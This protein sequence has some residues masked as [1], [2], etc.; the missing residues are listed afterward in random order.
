[1]TQWAIAADAGPD[2][3]AI[4]A[5]V[6]TADFRA[7]FYPGGSFSLDTAMGWMCQV[8]G[9]ERPLATLRNQLAERGRRPLLNHLPLRDLDR[10]ATGHG[11]PYWQGWPAHDEPDDEFWKGRR[12]AA[13]RGEGT[14]PVSLVRRRH[15]HLPP[16]PPPHS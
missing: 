12:F 8:A 13:T 2:L 7:P 10:L 1:M 15:R 4:A 11:V 6:T 16:P 5:Q 3:G 9:Q 14:A